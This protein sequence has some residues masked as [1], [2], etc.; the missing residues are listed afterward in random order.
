MVPKM[1]NQLP[2]MTP[3]DADRASRN[4]ALTLTL[5]LPG[6][7]VLYLLLPLHAAVFGVSLPEAGVLLA[8]NR[9][10]RIAGYGWVARFYA[11]KGPRTACLVAASGAFLSTL[12]YGLLSGIWALVLCRLMWGLSFAAMN[13]ANQ[14]LPT[15]VPEGAAQRSGRARSLTAIGPMTGLIAGAVIAELYG[16]RIVFVML[17]GVALLAFLFALQLP[18]EPE[19]FKL[20]GPRF[21]KPGVLSIWSFCLGFTLDGLFVFGLSLLAAASFPQGAVIAAGAAMALRYASE[22]VLSPAGGAIGQRFG[23]R[24][25]L[26]VASLGASIMLALLATSGLTLWIG[27]IAVVILRAVAQALQAPVVADAF[28]GPERVPALARQ[29]TWRDIGAGTGP[30]AAG[31][32]LPIA[33]ALLVYGGAALMMGLAS[34]MLIERPGRARRFT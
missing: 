5:A 4:A 27:V 12:G 8:A 26:V 25:V 29:A 11:E 3:A 33:P 30:L 21:A 18:S 15:A 14:A 10:V 19:R 24:R 1:G 32:L 34:A 7:T 20:G 6:D 22:L 16:P 13:I 2:P 28:P 9:L 31:I 23:P 17:A